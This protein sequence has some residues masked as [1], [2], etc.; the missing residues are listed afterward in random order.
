MTNRKFL[1]EIFQIPNNF[2]IPRQFD[3]NG[4]L[5]LIE[6][7]NNI[8]HIKTIEKTIIH[9]KGIGIIKYSPSYNYIPTEIKENIEENEFVNQLHE[10]KLPSGR[11]VKLHIIYDSLSNYKI[12]NELSDKVIL[13][14]SFLDNISSSKC[15][16]RLNIYILRTEHLKLLPKPNEEIGRSNANSAFTFSCK[17]NNEIFIFRKEESFKVFVHETI[18]NFGLDFS[19]LD[20]KK[21]NLVLKSCFQGL[22]KSV[23]YKI[24]ESYCEIWAQLINII[25]KVKNQRHAYSK[26]SEYIFYEKLW[27]I[28]QC[29]KILN[30]Y[31]ITYVNLF[32]DTN[33]YTERKTSIFSYYVLKTIGL[34]NINHFLNYCRSEN[35][36]ILDFNQNQEQ[37]VKY[38][39]LLCDNSNNLELKSYLSKMHFFFK[40]NKNTKK[41]IVPLITLRMSLYG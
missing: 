39:N 24:Y 36:H 16:K 22:D 35:N 15:S 23:D 3:Q 27:S 37:I 40:T 1:K 6:L 4:E 14:L 28:F 9:D 25:F 19:S 20:Q 32:K 5:L 17:E 41:Y 13:W 38:C 7:I 2:V 11:K 21:A 12:I 8:S 29:S 26:V 10:F 18:H 30:H 33:I 34:I 31:K